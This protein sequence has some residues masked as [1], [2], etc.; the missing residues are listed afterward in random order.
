MWGLGEE[1]LGNGG[2]GDG[3]RGSYNS[4]GWLLRRKLGGGPRGSWGEVYKYFFLSF[5]DFFD[6]CVSVR[7]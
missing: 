1:V 5:I 4:D 7:R 3:G 6:T 2:G